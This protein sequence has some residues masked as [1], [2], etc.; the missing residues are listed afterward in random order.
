MGGME[1]V[2]QAT[3]SSGH[4]GNT[5]VNQCAMCGMLFRSMQELSTH[6]RHQ[7]AL[8]KCRLCSMVLREREDYRAH[9]ATV[10]GQV[11]VAFCLECGKGFKSMSGFRIHQ[12]IWHSPV[13]TCPRCKT[14]GKYF[15]SKSRLLVHERKHTTESAFACFKCGKHYRYKSSLKKHTCRQDWG[16]DTNLAP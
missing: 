3:W 15:G 13:K 4:R 10:H 8:F 9:L 12:N 11:I 6:V 5:N 14:C 16:M 7:C 1:S 2:V